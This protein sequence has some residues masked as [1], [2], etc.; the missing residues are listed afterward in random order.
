[1]IGKLWLIYNQKLRKPIN[2]NPSQT[3]ALYAQYLL[4]TNSTICCPLDI[5]HLMITIQYSPQNCC[6]KLNQT[7]YEP[8]RIHDCDKKIAKKIP[9]NKKKKLS[10]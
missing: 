1:M 3:R 5:H 7:Q 2:S 4:S 6:R 8:P 9:F 10:K